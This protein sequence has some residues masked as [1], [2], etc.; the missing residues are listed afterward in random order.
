MH[1]FSQLL[2]F[3]LPYAFSP[4]FLPFQILLPPFR[5]HLIRHLHQLPKTPL[6][7]RHLL[8]TLLLAH[9]IYNVHSFISYDLVFIYHLLSCQYLQPNLLFKQL[10]HHSLLAS[11]FFSYF[12]S[13]SRYS[14]ILLLHLQISE[15]CYFSCYLIRVT[16]YIIIR[17]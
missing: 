1:S 17:Y 11:I 7:H 4:L 3:L 9:L 6:F 5:I 12:I 13:F 10:Y 14:L 15:S 8:H 16:N 2:L